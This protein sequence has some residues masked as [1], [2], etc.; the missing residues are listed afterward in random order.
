MGHQSQPVP[1][2]PLAENPSDKPDDQSRTNEKWSPKDWNRDIF[3]TDERK[4]SL[5]TVMKLASELNLLKE[6][7][8]LYQKFNTHLGG[9]HHRS[10]ASVPDVLR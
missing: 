9:K 8:E 5:T 3:E 2:A 4:S 6:Y 10:T 1:E 7:L